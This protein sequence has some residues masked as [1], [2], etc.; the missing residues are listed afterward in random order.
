MIVRGCRLQ[1]SMLMSL[2][3]LLLQH[4]L[5]S[6]QLVGNRVL[7]GPATSL[8]QQRAAIGAPPPNIGIGLAN[9]GGIGM[10]NP[11]G[12]GQ[13]A[14]AIG[15]LGTRLQVNNTR[16]VRGNRARQDFV[17]S[18]RSDLDGFVGSGQAIGIGRVPSAVDNFRIETTKTKINRPL[19]PQPAKGM[20]YPRLEIDFETTASP[21]QQLGEGPASQDVTDRVT[22]FSGGNASVSMAGSTAI[23]RGKVNSIRTSELL[24]QLLSFE[25]GIDR[26]K[27]ELSVP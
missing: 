12:I 1:V 23:L 19:P 14:N 25:P 3:A 6:A 8:T 22:Q 10:A 13:A 27:N 20:Y 7:G 21:N 5:A 26:V 9:T 18:N 17:G 2:V 15:S 11:G 4:E 24:V 16:F